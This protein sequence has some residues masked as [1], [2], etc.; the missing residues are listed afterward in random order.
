MER[1]R[2][3]QHLPGCKHSEA[4]PGDKHT[5]LPITFK[6]K[7]NSAVEEN[8]I[9]SGHFLFLCFVLYLENSLSL[10]FLTH[11]GSSLLWEKPDPTE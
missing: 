7:A 6:F 5:P 1:E 3:G 8:M 10:Q 11:Q 2:E 9:L 4:E